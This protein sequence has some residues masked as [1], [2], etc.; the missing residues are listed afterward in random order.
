MRV[1][2][3]PTACS[4]IVRIRPHPSNHPIRHAPLGESSPPPYLVRLSYRRVREVHPRLPGTENTRT[5]HTDGAAKLRVSHG[6][7]VSLPPARIILYLS[8]VRTRGSN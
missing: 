2:V 4:R 7:T 5:R 3:H 6:R 1:T 8:R